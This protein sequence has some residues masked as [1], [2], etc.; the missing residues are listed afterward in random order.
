MKADTLPMTGKTS[1]YAENQTNCYFPI[2]SFRVIGMTK[3]ELMSKFPILGLLVLSLCIWAGPQQAKSQTTMSQRY[4][5]E[6]KEID[7]LE[8]QGLPQSALSKVEALYVRIKKGTEPDQ[9]VKAIIYREKF[10]SQLEEKGQVKAIQRL[11]AEVEQS[12]FPVKQVLYSM[13]GELYS[14]YLTE[15]Y[16][17]IAQRTQ[18]AGFDN[19][20]LETWSATQFMETAS[21]YYN[22]SLEDER[23]LG[24]PIKNF[25]AIMTEGNLDEPLRPTLYDFLAHRVID[26][27]SNDR[28]YLPAPAYKFYLNQPEVFGDASA[29]VAL[30]FET[31]DQE[32]YQLKTVLLLQDLIRRHLADADPVALIDVDLKRLQF[33]R[34]K[35]SVPDKESLYLAALNRLKA[36]YSAS[37]VYTE[38]LHAIAS[39][40]VQQPYETG[41]EANRNNLITAKEL[42]DEAI[43]R[44][45]KSYGAAHCKVLLATIL[46]K[47]FSV[48]VELVNLPGQSSLMKV[49]YRN[50]GKLY[51]KVVQ[52]EEADIEALHNRNGY[53]ED[54]PAFT[55]RKKSVLSWSLALPATEDYRAHTTETIISK[56]PLGYYA[57][58]AAEDEK[59]DK[60]KKSAVYALFQVSNIAGIRR[61]DQKGSL[62]MLATDRASG[63]P[64]E[65]VTAEFYTYDY[66]RRG[67]TGVWKKVDTAISDKEGRIVPGQRNKEFMVK[68]SKGKDVFWVNDRFS[69]YSYGDYSQSSV[70]THFFLDRAI[71]RPGQTIYFKAIILEKDKSGIPSILTNRKVIVSFFDANQQEVAKLELMSNQYGSVNG[72]FIA[73]RT[74]L[75]GAMSIQS[76]LNGYTG[77]RVEEYK[78]PKFEVKIDPIAGA[79]KLGDNIAVTGV[80][81]MYAGSNVDG[82]QVRYRVVREVRYPWWPW[83]KGRSIYPPMY[84]E[85]MEIANGETTT[86][87]NGKFTVQFTALPD[88]STDK[89]D[90]PSFHYT[91]YTDV[92]DI[93]GETHS[94]E[95]SVELGYLSLTAGVQLPEAFDRAQAP[96]LVVSTNN[97]DGEHV[98]SKGKITIQRLDSPARYYQ[99][100]YWEKPDQYTIPEAAFKTNFPSIAYKKE[101]ERESWAVKEQVY[102]GDLDTGVSDSLRIDMGAWAV[103]Y[104]VVTVSVTDPSGQPVE[105]KSYYELFDR[106]AKQVAPNVLFRHETGKPQYE[107]GE[108]AQLNLISGVATPLNVRLEIENGKGDVIARWVKLAQW[109]EELQAI[110]EQDRGNLPYLLTFIHQNRFYTYSGII[111]VPW[112]NKDLTITYQTFRDKLRPGQEEEWQLKISGPKKESVAAEMVAAMY[113]AS[114][115]ALA[116]HNWSASFYPYNYNRIYWYG[117]DFRAGDSY[118]LP[119]SRT[120]VEDMDT[121]MRAY[122]QL[123]WFGWIGG[124]YYRGNRRLLRKNSAGA[125]DSREMMDQAAPEMLAAEAAPGAPPPPPQPGDADSVVVFAGDEESQEAKAPAPPPSVRT[126]LKE[127]VFFFPQLNTD[128]EGNILIKF[129]MN[130]ALTRWKFMAFAHTKTLQFGLSSKEIVTQKELMVLPN[131]PRFVREGDQIE[132]TAKVTNLTDK[133]LKGSARLLLFDAV[134]MEPVD[135]LLGNQNNTVNFST[136]AG[137]SA[138]LAWNLKIPAG[139]V[140]ALTH[141]I[142]ADA[143]DFADGEESAIPVLTNRMLVTET[144][145]LPVRGGQSKSFTLKNLSRAGDSRTL[146]H[147]QLSL[148][149]TSNPAWYAVKALPYLMEYPYECTEQIFNRFYANSLASAAAN[150]HPKIKNVFEAWKNTDALESNLTKNQDLKSALLEETPWVLEAQSE[151][152]QRQHIGLLFDL[153]RMADEKTRALAQLAERQSGNGGFAWF[154][155]GRE[156][157][158]ITQYIVEGLGHLNKL[159]VGNGMKSQQV[160]E[161]S[162]KAIRFIDLELLEA[163]RELEK[164]VRAERT[165]FEDDH[166]D[167][168]VIHYLYA[169]SFFKEQTFADVELAKIHEYYLGQAEKYWTGKGMYEQ[170]LLALALRRYDKKEVALRVMRSL[171]ERALKSEELGMYWNYP[172]GYFWN[173]LPIETHALLTEA[174]SEVAEDEAMVEELKIWLLKNK[175]TNHWKTTKATAAAVYVLL[176]NGA[177]WLTEDAPV[178]VS[179]PNVKKKKAYTE[180]IA[181]AQ[182]TAEAGTGYFRSNWDGDDINKD[183][184][185]VKVENPNKTVAWGGLY[186]Q[187]FENLDKIKTFEETPL[188]LKKQLFREDASDTGPVLR[189]INANTALHPGDKVVVRIELRVDRDMEYVHLKDM[190]ASSFEPLNVLSSYKWQGGLGYYESTRDAATNF[191]FDQLYKGTYV[192][193]YAVRATH[194]GNFSNGITSIQCMYAPEF[195]SH[196]EGIRVDV[197]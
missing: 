158:Y 15:N 53:S 151:A 168:V 21:K 93:N 94:A 58:L 127:T 164:N 193:E 24:I 32:S 144:L 191:F 54:G 106:K 44:F 141:R 135:Q 126:N 43:R 34:E 183:W 119:W 117:N 42:C 174:F 176:A 48:Q 62:L 35:S 143:G 99:D 125:M 89:K 98:A 9:F 97:L 102:A 187:Y 157:W 10:K 112:S 103:G 139:K 100:R 190:R 33:L 75:M 61:N 17:Q 55:K 121:P 23:L 185:K 74:G 179:F 90:R 29:F 142:V 171:K 114:L 60:G 105:S 172:R 72:N 109:K 31:K 86:D 13:L 57:V 81:Q 154:A 96:P 156:S 22:L 63:A 138:R 107:P 78:R 118:N 2:R 130:E 30:K 194:K 25:S 3:N 51:F 47:D 67:R 123:N 52:L 162:E 50:V 66:E 147:H 87:A 37:P 132:W 59:F 115:D 113:D 150:R 161:I 26:Y 76:S 46:E 160:K 195:S 83:W 180:V 149:F 137:Q 40:H 192:F 65:G 166:L 120:R 64:M 129:T 124:G 80:A 131:A 85:S 41:Q 6:W 152:Q 184:S 88:P 92:T 163:Y 189:P 159:G 111:S 165:K 170:G 155:G 145:P 178:K 104:Y 11:E 16:W 18:T 1:Y 108:E 73:P 71:Y 169:R 19:N 175:Q 39:W 146:Q 128:A 69:D 116:P 79:P 4:E 140:M 49:N 14:Q 68:L 177:N 188:Q 84:G 82:A 182:K 91:V 12:D 122:R 134:S 28:S 110:T 56:L 101:D 133:P 77:L 38:I 45:P 95:R 197:D 70:L 181:T 8:A 148:E 167:G 20:D 7:S 136:E 36:R 27:F 5:A 173:Q 153:N 186:W 196:S